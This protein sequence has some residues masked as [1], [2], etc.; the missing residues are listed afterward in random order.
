MG[1]D[2]PGG[3][4]HSTLGNFAERTQRGKGFGG[5]RGSVVR[6][7]HGS[8]GAFIKALSPIGR[9]PGGGGLEAEEIHV[10]MGAVVRPVH[11]ARLRGYGHFL[12][13]RTGR[14]SGDPVPVQKQKPIPEI[15]RSRPLQLCHGMQ[16]PGGAV[17]ARLAADDAGALG[18]SLQ[19]AAVCADHVHVKEA[20]KI[21][22]SLLDLHAEGLD[23]LRRGVHGK[24]AL[25]PGGKLAGEFLFHGQPVLDKAQPQL[26]HAP[27][28]SPVGQGRDLHR[29][30]DVHGEG[31][32]RDPVFGE[33]GVLDGHPFLPGGQYLA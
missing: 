8:P 7:Y 4:E 18:V 31:D 26:L 19:L 3:R 20:A 11:Q 10:L 5:S 2:A 15:R 12:Q 21:S 33:K 25:V 13:Q 9:Q 28:E 27:E 32:H 1:V 6:L 24:I 22:V 23:P 17:P 14:Q 16:P 29:P 30:G